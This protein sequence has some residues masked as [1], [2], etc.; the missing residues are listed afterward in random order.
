MYIRLL[1][2]KKSSSLANFS[3]R[4]EMT[5]VTQAMPRLCQIDPFASFA[6]QTADLLTAVVRV[7]CLLET[8]YSSSRCWTRAEGEVFKI[9][10]IFI[11][12]LD[13]R[14][15]KKWWQTTNE[16]TSTLKTVYFYCYGQ[17]FIIWKTGS[18][19]KWA[20][21]CIN[22]FHSSLADYFG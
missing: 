7:L 3:W 1:P 19:W 6:C 14:G 8:I 13:D 21:H 17:A 22:I 5:D 15:K 16:L 12:S 11:S 4:G 2:S 20:F 10:V 18:W 9:N